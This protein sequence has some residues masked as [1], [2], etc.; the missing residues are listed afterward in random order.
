VARFHHCVPFPSPAIFD[1]DA[2]IFGGNGQCSEALPP[3]TSGTGTR[4][5]AC[6]GSPRRIPETRH[7]PMAHNDRS[8]HAAIRHRPARQPRKYPWDTARPPRVP[9]ASIPV[10]RHACAAHKSC[11]YC[12]SVRVCE[13][14][15][16]I[17]LRC[18]MV[19]S[20]DTSPSNFGRGNFI[21]SPSGSNGPLLRFRAGR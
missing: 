6:F 14:K 20:R 13:R 5:P 1:G 7:D 18:R 11:E 15:D 4:R 9:P 12:A 19:F 17:V 8:P 3:S 21:D 2:F 10:V 16:R